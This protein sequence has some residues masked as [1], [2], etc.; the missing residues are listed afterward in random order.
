LTRVSLVSSSAVQADETQDLALSLG[1]R[2]SGV[3]VTRWGH[4]TLVIRAEDA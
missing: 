1:G 4:H 3:R 2:L